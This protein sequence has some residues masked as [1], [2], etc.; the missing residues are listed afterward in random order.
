M[1]LNYLTTRLLHLTK[2]ISGATTN[3]I[4]AVRV[5]MA[6]QNAPSDV[7]HQAHAMALRP[8]WYFPTRA[9]QKEFQVSKARL[10]NVR[11]ANRQRSQLQVCSLQSIQ[12]E[13][14]L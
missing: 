4:E 6:N 5:G 11:L 12:L 13:R 3:R 7:N 9:T 8:A 2:L 14:Q 1:P 10:P